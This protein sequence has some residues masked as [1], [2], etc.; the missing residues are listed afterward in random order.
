MF[1]IIG[2]VCFP[3]VLIASLSYMAVVGVTVLL[4]I[5]RHVRHD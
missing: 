1:T 4:P 2:I 3:A 5:A